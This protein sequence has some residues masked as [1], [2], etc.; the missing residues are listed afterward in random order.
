VKE[1][2]QK[3]LEAEKEARD[4]IERSRAEAQQIVRESE[5][6]SRQVEEGVRQGAMQKSHA[7]MEQMKEEAEAERRRQVEHAQVGSAEIIRKKKVEIEAAAGRVTNLILGIEDKQ[8]N[9]FDK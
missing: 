7:I 4:G 2:V 3:I 5:D 9:L 6:K 1:I 8:S